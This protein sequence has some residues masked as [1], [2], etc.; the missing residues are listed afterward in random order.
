MHPVFKV[1]GLAVIATAAVVAFV[2]SENENHQQKQKQQQDEERAH[3]Q[4][5]QNVHF[6]SSSEFYEGDNDDNDDNDD[7]EE[8][9]EEE[10]E[11]EF[12]DIEGDIS[13]EENNRAND[14]TVTYSD[15]QRILAHNEV[16]LRP[17]DGATIGI[18]LGTTTSC[19]GVW[20]N[21][22]VTIIPNSR[23][24][25]TTPSCVSFTDTTICTGQSDDLRSITIT[26][27]RNT[28]HGIKRLIGKK[29]TDHGVQADSDRYPFNIVPGPS[30]VPT[31]QTTCGGLRRIR[32]HYTPE[33]I[34]TIL[35]LQLK[36]TAEAHLQEPVSRAVVAVPAHFNDLQRQTTR[37]AASRAGLDVV[38]IINE[39]TAAAVAYG[40]GRGEEETAE[41]TVLVYDLGGGGLDVSLLTIGEG[42]YEVEATAADAR[43]GGEDFTDR[44]VHHVME[45]VA[46]KLGI[47]FRKDG[48]VGLRVRTECER[49]KQILSTQTQANIKMDSLFGEF[50]YNA[51]VTRD[52]FEEMCA[53]CFSRC[54][55]PVERVL[56][57]AIR[58]SR[59]D[60][61][62]VILVGGA[63]RMPMV[64]SLLAE[65]F[66][67]KEPCTLV[68]PDKA[69]A[70]G[71]TVQAA[72]LS[73]QESV[74]HAM[75]KTHCFDVTQLSFGLETDGGEMTTMVKR[76][77]TFPFLESTIFTT[78]V[79][80]L[81]GVLIRV[82]EGESS[83]TCNN[84]FLGEFR[85]DGIPCGR[86]IL[87]MVCFDIDDDG[88]L[89]VS[90]T[91]QSSGRESKLVIK[92]ASR[93]VDTVGTLNDCILT[94]YNPPKW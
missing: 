77:T 58:I 89:S 21:G 55:A 86:Q 17:S 52:Q 80:N 28:V 93:K 78:K 36:R 53:D 47:W 43:L 71:A 8:E 94:K 2:Q 62:E 72:I 49:A 27:A 29:F 22:G 1:I 60:V 11:V 75:S 90:A 3:N 81:E 33:D 59:A 45:E 34:S 7:N 87:I 35:L 66:D 74:P 68:D 18:D 15:Y 46:G 31:V 76:K 73:G 91:E 61:D 56:D 79:D 69:V 57:D 42:I 14:D 84:N 16:S 37:D 39:T 23:G 85:L 25:H 12:V 19:I 10:E 92:G 63:T 38:R 4:R 5:H 13:T 64:R 24:N 40:V 20:K 82:F 32:R 54:M 30:D 9:E 26:N 48:L 65:L 41:R 83:L 70:Y 67:G 51:T 88:I 50:S 44:L 6:D